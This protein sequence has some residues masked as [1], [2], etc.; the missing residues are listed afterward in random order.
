MTRHQASVGQTESCFSFLSEEERQKRNLRNLGAG[1]GL[2]DLGIFV[3]SHLSLCL[4]Q[5]NHISL[6]VGQSASR[7]SHSTPT[8]QAF[9]RDVPVTVMV[10]LSL[11]TRVTP[12]PLLASHVAAPLCE[13]VQAQ[14]YKKA[15][16]SDR[17]SRTC[18]KNDIL[19]ILWR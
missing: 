6:N 14:G 2:K 9:A 13:W 5:N 16:I 18:A 15:P 7:H 19:G 1:Q 11:P 4:K 17:R 12:A 10:C 8:P 3:P